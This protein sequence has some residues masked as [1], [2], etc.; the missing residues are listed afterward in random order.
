[1]KKVIRID[2]MTCHNCVRH[3]K[4]ALSEID[5]I[6]NIDVNLEEGTATIE[7]VDIDENLI[8]NEIEDFGYQVVSIESF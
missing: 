2:G 7:C 5:G 4:E 8:R 6:S 1:M 3:V